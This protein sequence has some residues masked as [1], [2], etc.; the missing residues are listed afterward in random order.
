MGTICVREGGM[1]EQSVIAGGIGGIRFSLCN[2]GGKGNCLCD[3]E[4]HRGQSVR[5]EET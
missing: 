5:K 3:R 1:G 4:G 2:I